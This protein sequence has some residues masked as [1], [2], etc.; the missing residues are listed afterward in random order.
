M[1]ERQLECFLALAETR[2]FG[3]AAQALYLTQPA[4]SQQIRAL[5]T[6]LGVQLVERSRA[7]VT[8]TPAG[9]AFAADAAELLAYQRAA[10][11]RARRSAADYTAIRTLHYMTP[12]R[13]LPQIL[14]A[15]H[16]AQPRVLIRLAH[17]GDL[18]RN[19]DLFR[20]RGDVTV[21][22]GDPAENYGD[23]RFLPLY[24]GGFVC[25]LPERHPLAGRE[26]LALEDVRGQQLF[27]IGAQMPA[28]VLSQLTRWL[29]LR[30]GQE[31]VVSPTFYQAAALAG[32][33]YG[34]AV[35]PR[36]M[37]PG[38]GTVQVPFDWPGQF[39]LGLFFS[40]SAPADV[41]QL[42]DIAASLCRPD[43]GDLVT[44]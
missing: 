34:V 7:G 30:T 44:M 8:L 25:V 10:V 32:A 13:R 36:L 2:H 39:S 38:P 24:T 40:R 35:V 26:R 15:F 11:Q 33:G 41:L 5:E 18:N 37:R 1:T 19:P 27:T 16:A 9:A 28:P 42:A 3:R 43:D 4:V 23:H 14:A 20:Q 29:A 31:P 12:L 22:F 17:G 21:L 6:D